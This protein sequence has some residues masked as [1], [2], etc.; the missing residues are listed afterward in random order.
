MAQ[1]KI[2]KNIYNIV[3]GPNYH[4]YNGIDYNFHDI[5]FRSLMISDSIHDFC[6]GSRSNIEVSFLKRN[7]KLGYTLLKKS[8][9][10]IEEATIDQLSINTNLVF[11]NLGNGDEEQVLEYNPVAIKKDMSRLIY[12]IETRVNIFI[13]NELTTDK[14]ADLRSKLDD[15]KELF[16]DIEIERN[17]DNKKVISSE[18]KAFF[19][20]IYINLFKA[21]HAT[22]LRYLIDASNIS[23]KS[24]LYKSTLSDIAYNFQQ[25]IEETNKWDMAPT[26]MPDISDE[27]KSDL[28]N[29]ETKDDIRYILNYNP[30][31]QIMNDNKY[32]INYDNTDINNINIEID[33][34]DFKNLI[35]NYYYCIVEAGRLKQ[36]IN[37]KTIPVFSENMNCFPINIT[38]A[39]NNVLYGAIGFNH[40]DKILVVISK[41]YRTKGENEMAVSS[42]GD[43]LSGNEGNILYHKVRTIISTLYGTSS[44]DVLNSRIFRFIFD[45]KRVGD[46]SQIFQVFN[47]NDIIDD[48]N[49]IVFISLDNLAILVSKLL[50]I[51]Y[52]HTKK[53]EFNFG[54]IMRRN[55]LGRLNNPNDFKTLCKKIQIDS[56]QL[57]TSFN[58]NY[59]KT[60]FEECE[61]L[62]INLKR[63][64]LETNTYNSPYI[65]KTFKL[66]F[67]DRNI[68]PVIAKIFEN[69]GLFI[70][71]IFR[72]CIETHLNSISNYLLVKQTID[73]TLTRLIGE[74]AQ[75]IPQEQWER[76]WNTIRKLVDEQEGLLEN[77]MILSNSLKYDDNNELTRFI[78]EIQNIEADPKTPKYLLMKFQKKLNKT[79]L[80]NGKYDFAKSIVF[81]IDKLNTIISYPGS[82]RRPEYK[83]LK[84]NIN[85]VY[86]TLININIHLPIMKP[87]LPPTNL[88]SVKQN[89]TIL[90]KHNIGQ[91]I[92]DISDFIN[93]EILTSK[94][95]IDG[96]PNRLDEHINILNAFND[97]IK[98]NIQYTFTNADL[99]YHFKCTDN[100]TLFQINSDDIRIIQRKLEYNEG[101]YQSMNLSGGAPKEYT[102]IPLVKPRVPIS[103]NKVGR[104]NQENCKLLNLKRYVTDFSDDLHPSLWSLNILNVHQLFLS[105]DNIDFAISTTI[106]VSH[107]DPVDYAK[108]SGVPLPIIPFNLIDIKYNQID[109]NL[110]KIAFKFYCNIFLPNIYKYRDY[111]YNN[112]KVDSN[113]KNIT[114]G[115][116]KISHFLN[117]NAVKQ[118]LTLK[119]INLHIPH[120][121]SS[122]SKYAKDALKYNSVNPFI[123]IIDNETDNNII[124]F[125][126]IYDLDFLINIFNFTNR[127]REIEQHDLYYMSI[128]RFLPRN[129]LTQIFALD[130]FLHLNIFKKLLHTIL[131]NQINASSYVN[132]VYPESFKASFIY[133][134]IPEVQILSN[135]TLAKSCLFCF[136]KWNINVL[137]DA[138]EYDFKIGLNSLYRY[139]DTLDEQK[140]LTTSQTVSDLFNRR[141]DALDDSVR[142]VIGI[143]PQHKESISLEDKKLSS[144][145]NDTKLEQSM[146]DQINKIT[147]TVI[148]E[149]IGLTNSYRYDAI[150]MSVNDIIIKIVIE[151]YRIYSRN[152]T[153]PQLLDNLY[154]FQGKIEYKDTFPLYNTINN[155]KCN[156]KSDL[157]VK[158]KIYQELVNETNKIRYNP[159]TDGKLIQISDEIIKVRSRAN[160][161]FVNKEEEDVCKQKVDA[162]SSEAIGRIFP[163]DAVASPSQIRETVDHHSLEEFSGLAE[164]MQLGGAI[165][166]S[167]KL[168][169]IPH[170]NFRQIYHSLKNL[171]HKVIEIDEFKCICHFF[172]IDFPN[173]FNYNIHNIINYINNH[174]IN[175]YFIYRQN[176]VLYSIIEKLETYNYDNFLKYVSLHSTIKKYADIVVSLEKKILELELDDS[177]CVESVKQLWLTSLSLD[178][179][180][181]QYIFELYGENSILTL[182]RS[183]ISIAELMKE[184]IKTSSKQT[185]DIADMVESSLKKET[186]YGGEKMDRSKLK[187]LDKYH[188]SNLKIH[189][190]D[191]QK[192][193]E[194]NNISKSKLEYYIDTIDKGIEANSQKRSKSNKK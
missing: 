33:K 134:N 60:F 166:D 137:I 85:D 26:M 176:L 81:I 193:I 190:K 84:K 150:D 158:Y 58:L 34:T 177:D 115:L 123:N 64:L 30:T 162:L 168:G 59:N 111:L 188:Y 129:K 139:L 90:T 156:I 36:P 15:C 63:I 27:L 67:F 39:R 171:F 178:Y 99:E 78:S 141:D 104:G 153:Y 152:K 160:P 194:N 79:R 54:F 145:Y 109:G 191:I 11:Y 19:K 95:I 29:E 38:S 103:I 89:P 71:N 97:V 138:C 174:F 102:D 37:G 41:A 146:K 7:L 142:A 10:I 4:T 112:G 23:F 131:M 172:D 57:H 130:W 187:T 175:R 8:P 147:Q 40:G 43:A 75:P 118:L 77:L 124:N 126:N 83:D 61:V 121:F 45:L 46:W 42:L 106:N 117:Y 159:E 65:I 72:L 148:D 98:K 144:D 169:F 185:K 182:D 179:Y 189:A 94:R 22:P 155:P 28:S 9:S 96:K 167:T 120:Y 6:K 76:E 128:I 44:V 132:R 157:D 48:N 52:I 1:G 114:N 101:D 108:E 186:A 105:N 170:E 12:D 87:D 151:S 62:L 116:Y 163:V 92:L 17:A 16:L 56:N 183:D 2:D 14:Y 143:T 91:N 66:K 127:E 82:S 119:N 86:H 149:C 154:D 55:T 133:S 3:Q 73:S 74:G 80:L 113:T 51:N 173:D 69:I 125:Y 47:D 21:N 161:E 13:N 184:T 181:E 68:E 5:I 136:S 164:N 107:K 70:Y 180:I 122:E 35:G 32:A 49:K 192:I 31:N 110:P 18:I 165:N 140:Y 100:T 88:F 93:K 53:N 24:L 50:N 20:E 135:I 25:I